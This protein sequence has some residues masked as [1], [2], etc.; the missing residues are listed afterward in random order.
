M[1]LEIGM[2][3]STRGENKRMNTV[4]AIILAILILAIF[5]V[6]VGDTK[7]EEKVGE[8]DHNSHK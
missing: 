1:G 2:R 7:D 5:L 8:I 4:A 3:A 6:T